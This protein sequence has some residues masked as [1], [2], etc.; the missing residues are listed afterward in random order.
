MINLR[1]AGKGV[2]GRWDASDAGIRR[3]AAVDGK[4]NAGDEGCG[5]VIEQEQN[6]ADQLLRL[7]EAPHRGR[8]KDFAGARRGRAVRVPQ[9]PGAMALTRMPILE[10]CTASH[11][12]KLEIAAF[13]PEY[14]GILVSGV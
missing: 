7:A 13:A 5:V 10:K 14:A 4:D 8:G 6:R 1:P 9:K 11:C 12:V 3:E 2:A